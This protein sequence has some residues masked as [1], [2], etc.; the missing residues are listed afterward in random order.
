MLLK[1]YL[2]H[3]H[4]NKHLSEYV[5]ISL[6]L[7]CFVLMSVTPLPVL[8]F[9]AEL[10]SSPSQ[11]LVAQAKLEGHASSGTEQLVR[12]PNYS[13]RSSGTITATPPVR[14][15]TGNWQTRRIAYATNTAPTAR[16][17]PTLSSPLVME[18]EASYYSRAG[19]LGCSP[20]LTMANGQ[21]LDDNA[22]TMAIGADKKH[23]VGHKAKVTNI[24]TGQS[25]EVSITDT[26][27][28]YKAKYGHR[29]ADLTVA[30]K[31]A[32]GI[33]GGVGQVKVEV[34]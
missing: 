14:T 2:G 30:S 1:R 11:K 9:E 5:Y 13:H 24:A 25:V 29:V 34:Y 33:A 22:L 23:L 20:A 31:Q 16:V 19:C 3:T 27:G 6:L 18:G 12:L 21:P 28:F 15:K 10:A 7:A 17:F 4:S 26:G 8:A 32:I